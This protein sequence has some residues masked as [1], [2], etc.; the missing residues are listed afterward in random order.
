[1]AYADGLYSAIVDIPGSLFAE[2]LIDAYPQAKVVMS[3][4]NIDTWSV[5]SELLVIQQ[6]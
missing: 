2:E 1:M 3:T 5:R 6:N 4:R